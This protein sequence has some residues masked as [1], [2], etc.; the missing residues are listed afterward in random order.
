MPTIAIVGIDTNVGKTIVTGLIGRYLF[1]AGHA[2]VTQKI[3]QTGCV[4]VSEDIALHRRLMGIELTDEDR[5]GTTCPYIFTLPASPHLSAQQEQ[6]RIDSERIATATQQLETRYE[7]VLLEGVGGLYVPLNEEITLL[8]YLAERQYPLIVVSSAKLGSIN[9]TLLT[10]DI[11]H[12]RKL[13]VLG[14]VYNLHPAEHR[15]IVEDSQRVF[16]QYLRRFGYPETIVTIPAV[17]I[18]KPIPE[19]DFSTLFIGME[20]ANLTGF[21]NL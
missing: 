15:L 10:L 1:Q 18:E 8:D 4:G 16:R 11:A 6:Q 14:I 20:Y 9:H 17:D 12:H 19:I 7:Y 13:S 5:Q 21:E 2:V 3:A